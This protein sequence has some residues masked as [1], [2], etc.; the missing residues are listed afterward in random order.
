M[1]TN[2]IKKEKIV[3]ISFLDHEVYIG[4]KVLLFKTFKSFFYHIQQFAVKLERDNF[5]PV[6][7]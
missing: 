6:V 2:A 1:T 7:I 4:P 3:E 5:P